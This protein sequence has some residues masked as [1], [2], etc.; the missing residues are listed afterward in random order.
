MWEPRRLT[1]L[2]ASKACYRDSFTFFFIQIARL[3]GVKYL[4][5]EQ[6]FRPASHLSLHNKIPSVLRG[7][8][9]IQCAEKSV[10]ALVAGSTNSAGRWCFEQ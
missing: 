10:N 4:M 1:T 2:W 6:C 5:N 8:V 7:I 3:L 9:A